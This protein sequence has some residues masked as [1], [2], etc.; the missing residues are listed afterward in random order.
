[1]IAGIINE[2]GKEKAAMNELTERKLMLMNE[3]ERKAWMIVVGAGSSG[4]WMLERKMPES[5]TTNN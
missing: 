4:D 2:G 1:M 5:A 3:I